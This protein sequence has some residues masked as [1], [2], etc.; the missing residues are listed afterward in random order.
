MFRCTE[1]IKNNVSELSVDQCL[2]VLYATFYTS[3][4]YT[5]K[6]AV[7]SKCPGGIRGTFIKMETIL[8]LGHNKADIGGREAGL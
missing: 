7:I 4:Y 2:D 3:V 1:I 8:Y 5:L 6:L